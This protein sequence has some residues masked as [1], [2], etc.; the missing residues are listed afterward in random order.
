MR[1]KTITVT[2]VLMG[3]LNLLGYALLID[4]PK[5]R[6]T[7]L[8]EFLIFT[9]LIAVGYVVLWFYWQGH[10]WARLLVLATCFLCFFNFFN[11]RRYP[12]VHPIA[13]VIVVGEAA[14]AAFLV[15]WLN[16]SQA[17]AFF[18]SKVGL[19]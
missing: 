10:N 8:A 15:Y 12:S 18:K 16:T 4:S 2:T 3:I 11:L 14:V 6:P 5:P 19:P 17:K 1:P 9:V 13:K 7:V